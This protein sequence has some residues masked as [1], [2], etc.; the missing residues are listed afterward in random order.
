MNVR[1]ETW[2][3]KSFFM[4][5]A[6]D[7]CSG[8]TKLEHQERAGLRN[9]R[10]GPLYSVDPV[11]GALSVKSPTGR[12]SD[13][14]FA[15]HFKGCGHTNHAGGRWEAP[16]LISRAGI[17]RSE[18]TL[19]QR[20]SVRALTLSPVCTPGVLSDTTAT[21]M[22]ASSMNEMLTSG[23]QRRGARPPTG[24]CAFS[25]SSEKKSGSM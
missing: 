22:L 17:E 2:G 12:D 7:G 21:S 20:A 15:I 4:S 13:V 9:H 5:F 1:R 14:L 3:A 23:D 19:Q 24:A 18:L 16:Q 8:S 25:V 10:C 11:L 6:P